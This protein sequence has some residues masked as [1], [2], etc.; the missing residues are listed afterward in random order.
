MLAEG[1]GKR[2]KRAARRVLRPATTSSCYE[3]RSMHGFPGI[4]VRRCAIYRP[5]NTVRPTYG[6]LVHCLSHFNV[7][8]VTTRRFGFCTGMGNM[9]DGVYLGRKAPLSY[10][11]DHDACYRQFFLTLNVFFSTVFIYYSSFSLSSSKNSRNVNWSKA[12][13]P[14]LGEGT[15]RP[16]VAS[17]QRVGTVASP[18]RLRVVQGVLSLEQQAS[19]ALYG[20]GFTLFADPVAK[21]RYEE[22][23]ASYSYNEVVSKHSL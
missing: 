9:L 19:S 18:H 10:K 1:G 3:Q 12:Y 14:P 17:S 7:F 20:R 6:L 16:L 5:S 13:L 8:R 21:C 11:P 2:A 15:T 22:C 4:P 23:Q